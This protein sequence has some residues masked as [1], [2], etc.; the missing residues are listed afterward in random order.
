[1]CHVVSRDVEDK[2][3]KWEARC[4]TTVHCCNL[5]HENLCMVQYSKSLPFQF[6]TS[7]LFLLQ[8]ITTL[9]A[10]EQRGYKKESH[11]LNTVYKCGSYRNKD[12]SS[13]HQYYLKTISYKQ[14]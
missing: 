2:G 14:T 7:T 3:Q 11:H 13:S 12:L 9:A 8:E 10:W 5:H 6:S 1:M 4:L